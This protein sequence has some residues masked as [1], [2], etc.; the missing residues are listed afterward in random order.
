MSP[1]FVSSAQ[2]SS[3]SGSAPTQPQGL[4]QR[5]S[6]P[7]ALPRGRVRSCS[8]TLTLMLPDPRGLSQQSTYSK[9]PLRYFGNRRLPPLSLG[10]PLKSGALELPLTFVVFEWSSS[11][12]LPMTEAEGPRPNRQLA[13]VAFPTE[14][15][16]REA[17][18]PK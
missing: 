5:A 8:Q 16:C 6:H 13:E 10:F 11:A 18:L 14:G 2:A 4:S 12:P 17:A 15:E 3:H 9:C 1:L 7:Q